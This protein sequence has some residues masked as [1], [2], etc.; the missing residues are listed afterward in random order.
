MNR[1]IILSLFLFL[2]IHSSVLRADIDWPTLVNKAF[3]TSGSDLRTIQQKTRSYTA[4]SWYSTSIADVGITG[5]AACGIP[6]SGYAALPAEFIYLMREIY[7][8]SLGL[9]FLIYG[10]ATKDDFATILGIWVGETVLDNKTLD[11]IYGVAEESAQYAFETKAEKYSK[12]HSVM[13]GT[14]LSG[15][16][17]KGTAIPS[18][19][20]VSKQIAKKTGVKTAGKL[21]T[22]VAT[23]VGAKIGGKYAVKASFSWVPFVSAAVCGSLN[24]W[25]MNGIMTAS[26]EYYHLLNNDR[27]KRYKI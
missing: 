10:S 8:S 1:K 17:S 16:K 6:L 24:M 25:I 7:N 4:D 5:G 14:T 18:K 12:T 3:E 9:G 15:A 11:V 26:E 23:K 2:G 21:S 27:N 13:A 19:K 22:K 20:M